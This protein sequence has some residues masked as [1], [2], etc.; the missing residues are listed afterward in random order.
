MQIHEDE[1]VVN[2]SMMMGN[3]VS[4]PVYSHQHL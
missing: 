3:S 2:M 1:S 4:N